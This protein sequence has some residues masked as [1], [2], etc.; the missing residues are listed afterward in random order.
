MIELGFDQ[1]ARLEHEPGV[2]LQRDYS[3]VPRVLTWRHSG[4]PA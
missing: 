1:A 3:G 4:A 2:E